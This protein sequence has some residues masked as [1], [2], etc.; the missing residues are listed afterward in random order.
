VNTA[1]RSL[2]L[3]LLALGL[4]GVLHA[5][6]LTD[7]GPDVPSSGTNDIFQLSTNGDQTWPDGR[8]QDGGLNSGNG[9]GTPASTP[10][11]TFAFI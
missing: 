4:T 6:T 8:L 5:Q 9:Y 2:V 3:Q 11:I 7:I 1:I 10:T